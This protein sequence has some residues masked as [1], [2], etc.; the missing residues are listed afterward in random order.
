VLPEIELILGPQPLVTPLGF[1][2]AQNRFIMM[3][4]NFLAV[5]ATPEHPLV[6]FS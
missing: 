6:V 2:E 3:V 1:T 5:L 4:Q